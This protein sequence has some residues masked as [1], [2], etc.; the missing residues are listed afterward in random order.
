[1]GNFVPR[2]Y[3]IYVIYLYTCTYIILHEFVCVFVFF[4]LFVVKGLT[5]LSIRT[6]PVA[7]IQMDSV[8][9]LSSKIFK[10]LA[11]VDSPDIGML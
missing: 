4:H 9:P 2:V 5:V 8:D 7:S 11:F 1:M 6:P 10:H 3:I